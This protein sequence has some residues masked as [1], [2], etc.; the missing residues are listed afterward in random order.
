LNLFAKNKLDD[1]TS[2]NLDPKI[3]AEILKT[4]KEEFI[5]EKENLLSKKSKK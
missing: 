5:K 1:K 2:L 4:L 3:K